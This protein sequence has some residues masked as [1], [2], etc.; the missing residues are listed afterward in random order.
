QN[1]C[2]RAALEALGSC[3]NNKYSEGYP[4]KRYYG[5]AEVVD[6]IELLCQQ[7]ALEAF[8]LDPA[9][10]GVNVQPYSGSPA[11]FAAY[12]ALLQPHD[13]L[14]GL[15][16]PDGG[17]WSQG[18]LTTFCLSVSQ[19]LGSLTTFF[20]SVCPSQPATGLIDYDQLEVTARLFRPR[21][22]IAG[23]SAYARLIDYARMKKV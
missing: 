14:M 10:W 13:R 17:H 16:L 19:S 22:V 9:R 4:G 21:L 6:Q 3:L 1:F 8:D 18:G 15:D 12:T 5:G 2:S 7:R 23:T 11:N 20:L